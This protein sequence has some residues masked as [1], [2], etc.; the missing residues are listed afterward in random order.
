MKLNTRIEN[1]ELSTRLFNQLHRMDVRTMK[2]IVRIEEEGRVTYMGF[3]VHDMVE[4]EAIITEYNSAI[5]ERNNKVLF[6]FV[7]LFTV[8]TTVYIGTFL[9]KA[10]AMAFSTH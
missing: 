4:I 2:D 3:G 9:V 1:L 5:E 6:A 10:L 7:A 8:A